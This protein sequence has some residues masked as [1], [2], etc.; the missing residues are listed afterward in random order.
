MNVEPE[1]S[2]LHQTSLSATEQIFHIEALSGNI[3][4]QGLKSRGGMNFQKIFK[5]QGGVQG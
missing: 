3:R 5:R 2:V 4:G 1:I